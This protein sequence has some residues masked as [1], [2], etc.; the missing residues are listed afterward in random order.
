MMKSNEERR[1]IDT[2][3]IVYFASTVPTKSKIAW[4]IIVSG[5]IVSVQVLNEFVNTARGPKHRMSWGEI[6]DVLAVV[7]RQF[8]IVALNDEQQQLA[9]S[10][11]E[12]HN[13]NIY[14]ATI[15]ASAID[16]S[17]DTLMSEDG[18]HGWTLGGLTIINPFRPR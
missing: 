15:I 10:I 1:F 5:G 2:N 13:R 4:D 9:V 3:I 18:H 11:A 6:H 7:R 17:C 14:D 8:E 12:R 16:S